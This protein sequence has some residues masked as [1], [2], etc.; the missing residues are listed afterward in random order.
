MSFCLVA[1]VSP[2]L[3]HLK[4]LGCAV[5][6]YLRGASAETAVYHLIEIPLFVDR[7]HI[8]MIMIM[9]RAHVH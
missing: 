3:S 8:I 1:A 5:P 2:D 7:S 6:A 4:L 9:L